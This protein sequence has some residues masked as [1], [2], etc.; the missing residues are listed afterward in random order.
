MRFGN[1]PFGNI[2]DKKSDVWLHH[3]NFEMTN[4][5]VPWGHERAVLVCFLASVSQVASVATRMLLKT[6]PS[7]NALCT[8]KT[9]PVTPWRPVEAKKAVLG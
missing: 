4:F 1:I 5:W 3:V 7:L 9:A 6:K 2:F 8:R